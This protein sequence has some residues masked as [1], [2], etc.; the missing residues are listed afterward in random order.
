MDDFRLQVL[1]SE[2][3]NL[4]FE[5]FGDVVKIT[6]SKKWILAL[7]LSVWVLTACNANATPTGGAPTRLPTQTPW[8]VYVPV[9]VTPEPVTVTPLPTVGVAVVQP[10]EVRRATATRAPVAV[11]PTATKP[12]AAPVAP[13][14]AAPTA[15]PV[16]KCSYGP[17][18][19]V[20]PLEGSRYATKEIGVGGSTFRFKWDPP[21]EL[22]G[23]VS[24]N[25]GY[26]LTIT[27]KKNGATLYLSSN[28]FWN[29]RYGDGT[30]K[31][32]I[33]DK[34]DV[35]ALASGEATAVTWTVTV[36]QVGG[37]FNEADPKSPPKGP[38]VTCG[39]SSPTRNINLDIY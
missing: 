11:K 13:V 5:I 18:S 30:P 28:G 1:K 4:K 20:E 7:A 35:S 6:K 36:V 29:G 33:F 8:V 12:P 14:A 27:A 21:P 32:V 15:V 24:N 17:V 38:I 2:I 22:Q 39:P 23:Q 34:P 31:L 16:A 25:V 37:D 9:T 26:R 3:C 19:L 10:T